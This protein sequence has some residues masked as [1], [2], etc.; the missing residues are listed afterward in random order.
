MM[1][2]GMR[3]HGHVCFR[4]VARGHLR[5]L[6]VIIIII[7]SGIILVLVVLAE[8]LHL[9][10]GEA[11]V[12]AEGGEHRVRRDDDAWSKD[13]PVRH[14]RLG[15][16]DDAV[17]AD[18]ALQLRALP[19]LDSVP[20][21]G[22]DDARPRRH[23]AL[24]PEHALA[25]QCAVAH[26][27]AAAE[28]A[29]VD[30]GAASHGDAV[31]HVDAAAAVPVAAAG[32]HVRVGRQ[33]ERPARHHVAAHLVVGIRVMHSR[34]VLIF[35]H[36]RVDGLAEHLELAKH[37]GQQVLAQVL[38]VE[39]VLQ[40]HEHLERADIDV[41]VVEIGVKLQLVSLLQQRG[42]E[43]QLSV[44]AAHRCVFVEQQPARLAREGHEHLLASS[45]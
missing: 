39:I 11:G 44:G 6:S 20:K 3:H 35:Y 18:A 8:C 7:I 12:A 9:L 30:L 28:D 43:P 4:G 40:E 19:N 13:D 1:H 21:V 37:A 24:A 23:E 34:R 33:R 16:N 38:P 36:L 25:Q 15:P 31:L 17:A 45:T 22:S 41:R 10:C 14:H 32:Q 5:R 42:R 2:I 29:A 27:R 26:A